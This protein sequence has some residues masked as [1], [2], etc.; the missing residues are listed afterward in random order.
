MGREI[1]AGINKIFG[2]RRTEATFGDAVVV[3]A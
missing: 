2:W 3:A 1:V